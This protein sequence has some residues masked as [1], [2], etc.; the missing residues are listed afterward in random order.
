MGLLI[1]LP[2]PNFAR[3][4]ARLGRAAGWLAHLDDLAAEMPPFPS[5]GDHFV[6]VLRRK[7]Q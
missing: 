1:F 6:T 7:P 4:Y 3:A 5:I 2:P